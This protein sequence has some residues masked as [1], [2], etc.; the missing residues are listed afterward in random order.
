MYLAAPF[1]VPVD[2][3]MPTKHVSSED[4]I[5]IVKPR[6]GMYFFVVPTTNAPKF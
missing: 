6:F 1:H 5:R 4:I 2:L 3:G